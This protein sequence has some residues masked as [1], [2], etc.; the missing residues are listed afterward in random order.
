MVFAALSN[1]TSLLAGEVARPASAFTRVFDALWAGREGGKQQ[2][3]VLTNT[4]LPN[5]PPAKGRSRPSSTGYGGRESTECVAK[6]SLIQ[7]Q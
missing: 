6:L 7:P 5:P 4:P 2:T 3:S 1:F